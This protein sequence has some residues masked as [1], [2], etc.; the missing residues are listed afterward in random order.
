MKFVRPP[1]EPNQ[2][3]D[4]RDVPDYRGRVRE[5]ESAMTVKDAEAP[6]RHYEKPGAGKENLHQMDR[7]FTRCIVK[8]ISKQTN[9]VASCQNSGEYNHRSRERQ[10]RQYRVRQARGF[11]LIAARQQIGVDRNERGGQRAFAKDILEE[12]RN[13]KGC[14]ESAGRVSDPE[15]VREDTLANHADDPAD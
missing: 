8:T 12:V 14:G 1:A 3:G 7:Q 4:D 15:I 10:H 6:G 5:K 9:E 13:S 2:R 11:L